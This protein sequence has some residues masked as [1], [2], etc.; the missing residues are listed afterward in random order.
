MWLAG[1]EDVL[2]TA[3]TLGGLVGVRIIREKQTGSCRG[4]GFLHFSSVSDATRSLQE[5][6]VLTWPAQIS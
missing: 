1:S 2:Q 5:L 3:V 4:F 6:Q